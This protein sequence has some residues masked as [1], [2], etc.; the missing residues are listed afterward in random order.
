MGHV[1][2]P[3]AFVD[4]GRKDHEAGA[5]GGVRGLGERHSIGGGECA[6]GRD[7]GDLA[8]E[9]GDDGFEDGNFFVES[10]G[11]GF[12]ER[13]EADDAGAA[14]FNEPRGVPGYESEVDIQVGVEGGSHGGHDALPVQG[15]V[16]SG[17][18]MRNGSAGSKIS[19]DSPVM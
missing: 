15:G 10:E 7:D 14:V 17:T 9:S 4:V 6:D 12:A 5:A 13:A 3:I 1:L 19:V 8:I 16:H 11:G 2:A 18:P